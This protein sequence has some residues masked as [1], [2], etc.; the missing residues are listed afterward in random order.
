MGQSHPAAKRALEDQLWIKLALN[1]SIVRVPP[2]LLV[3]VPRQLTRESSIARHG[4]VKHDAGETADFDVPL[5]CQAPEG[6]RNMLL[7]L[8]LL[9][10]VRGDVQHGKN[11]L[12][13]SGSWHPTIHIK[14]K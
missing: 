8:L 14:S 4:D 3:M 5:C 9:L 13:G 11:R 6:L 2:E 7:L 1:C 12:G 10:S